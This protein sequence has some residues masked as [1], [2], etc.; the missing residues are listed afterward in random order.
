M[1]RLFLKRFSSLFRRRLDLYKRLPHDSD[2]RIKRQ[3]FSKLLA[4]TKRPKFTPLS[5]DTPNS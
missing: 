5:L 2:M 3:I 1:P 4:R